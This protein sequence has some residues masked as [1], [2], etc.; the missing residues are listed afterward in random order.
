[1]PGRIQMT[2]HNGNEAYNLAQKRISNKNNY[3][4]KPLVKVGMDLNTTMIG[5]IKN[6][7]AGCGGCGK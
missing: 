3:S 1:M 7:P 6:A 4:S 5:R 2:F